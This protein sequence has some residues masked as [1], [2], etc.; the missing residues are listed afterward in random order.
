MARSTAVQFRGVAMVL[1]AY[2]ANDIPAY[3][4]LNGKQV[5]Y[6]YEGRDCTEGA[7]E[8][9]EF[10]NMLKQGGGE[11]YYTLQVYKMKVKDEI[12]SETPYARSFNF[13]VFDDLNELSPYGN[14]RNSFAT[15]MREEMAEMRAAIVALGEKKELEESEAEVKPMGGI[16]KVLND[17]WDHPDMKNA[18]MSKVVGFVQNIMPMKQT[19]PA[20][21]AGIAGQEPLTSVLT[22]DQVAKV[23]Q[24]LNVLCAK[25]PQ[26]GD[27]LLKVAALI[28]SNPGKYKMAISML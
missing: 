6:T 14:A 7:N 2:E 24:A 12:N 28:Q 21:M 10:L 23:H 22:E 16:G 25:D 11:G 5:L 17:I 13:T 18:I 8:L 27:N 19:T 26:L 3:A 9:R 20:Q 4:V 1:K 15:Q